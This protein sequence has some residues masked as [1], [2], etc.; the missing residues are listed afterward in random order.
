VVTVNSKVS[1]PHF[2]LGSYNLSLALASGHWCSLFRFFSVR[3]KLKMENCLIIF[4]LGVIIARISAIAVENQQTLEYYGITSFDV[5]QVGCPKIRDLK[6]LIYP[7]SVSS[8]IEQTTI[9]K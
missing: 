3:I 9:Y 5:Q 1:N 4:F 8:L 2:S 6:P 7:K